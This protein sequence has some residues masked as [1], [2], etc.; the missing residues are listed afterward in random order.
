MVWMKSLVGVC[1]ALA[2]GVLF[3][4]GCGAG[5][6]PHPTTNAARVIEAWSSALRRG[7]VDAAAG[8][9]AFPSV[10]V[11]GSG[12]SPVLTIHNLA[13]ARL[14]NET[15]PCGARLISTIRNGRYV[16]ALF[17]LTARPGPGGSNC[18][19]G[20]G[21]TARV[22]FQI[23]NGKIV[24]WL[25]APDRPNPTPPAPPAVSSGGGPTV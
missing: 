14:V 23:S 12:P 8:Y 16:N 13:Q 3:A 6:K 4:S 25:R 1:I 22:N 20:A 21:Q 18:G 17:R 15:L 7:D 9:F 19:S 10:F 24:A 2:S 11:N 5:P